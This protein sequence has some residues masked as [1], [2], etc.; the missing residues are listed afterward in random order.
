MSSAALQGLR[1]GVSVLKPGRR[2]ALQD[3]AER[4]GH[5]ATLNGRYNRNLLEIAVK[6][7]Q[8]QWYLPHARCYDAAVSHVNYR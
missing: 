4:E 1:V 6:N 2:V 5:R 8:R 7:L 3:H